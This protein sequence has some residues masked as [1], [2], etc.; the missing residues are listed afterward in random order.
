MCGIDIIRL[1]QIK[2]RVE[3]S[4]WERAQ[5]TRDLGA[6]LNHRWA[7]VEDGGQN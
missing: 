1:R 2:H 6:V 4:G 5:Q 7:S 3:G